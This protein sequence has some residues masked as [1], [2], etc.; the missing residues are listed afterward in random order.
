MIIIAIILIVIIAILI[1]THTHKLMM[2]GP[3]NR[4]ALKVPMVHIYIYIYIYIYLSLYIYIYRSISISLSLYL[5][6]SLS[7]YIYILSEELLT[8]DG[9]KNVVY[10]IAFNNP[11][12][13]P[14]A[15]RETRC[16]L[17]GEFTRLA[18]TRLA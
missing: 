2:R 15:S 7:I 13:D 17:Y 14:P 11:F 18:E 8:L 5:S 10:A 4:G 9:H 12:G 3:L 6:L 1:W 16:Y